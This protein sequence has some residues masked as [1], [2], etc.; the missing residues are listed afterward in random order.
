MS[1]HQALLSELGLEVAVDAR[2]SKL[3]DDDEARLGKP[4]PRVLRDMYETP[5]LLDLLDNWSSNRFERPGALR[6]YSHQPSSP[7]NR[8]LWLATE[9]QGVCHWVVPL[10]G[11]DDP[12]VYVTG[13]LR[14]GRSVVRYVASLTEFFAAVAWDRTGV[15]ADEVPLIQAQADPLDSASVAFLEQRFDQRA[16]THG[17]P[18][19]DNHRFQRDDQRIAL[20]SCDTQCDWWLVAQS[21]ASLQQLVQD[22]LHLSNLSESLWS[23]DLAGMEILS[24]VRADL[25]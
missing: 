19:E 23:N 17:W 8:P 10:D 18:C 16:T 6:T 21:P 4:L 13:D 2:I 24:R 12:P 20:W 1:S 14:S 7:A 15:D 25:T 3:L 5:G 11:S 9:N 22:V